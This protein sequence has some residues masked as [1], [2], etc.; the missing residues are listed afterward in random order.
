MA[1]TT[2]VRVPDKLKEKFEKLENRDYWASFAE[3]I[4]WC[5]IRELERQQRLEEMGY[6]EI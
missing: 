5:L 4:R 2:P 1:K 6:E 3:F